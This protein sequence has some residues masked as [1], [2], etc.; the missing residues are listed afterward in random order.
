[1]YSIGWINWPEGSTEA[2]QVESEDSQAFEKFRDAK[3]AAKAV[4]D[5]SEKLKDYFVGVR[6]EEG[7]R[8]VWMYP[9]TFVKP[10]SII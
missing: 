1:M 4:W 10:V 3:R 9:R 6:E 5:S 7:G 2:F 8:W